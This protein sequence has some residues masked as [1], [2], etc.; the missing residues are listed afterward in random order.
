MHPERGLG[1]AVGLVLAF[2]IVWTIAILVPDNGATATQSQPFGL[3]VNG[4]HYVLDKNVGRYPAQDDENVQIIHS[5]S[6]PTITKR[7]R[8]IPV[9]L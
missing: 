4:T 3:V 2:T 5:A 9:C 8:A 6:P 1:A 7:V